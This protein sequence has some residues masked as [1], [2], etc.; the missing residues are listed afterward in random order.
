MSSDFR[1]A[2]RLPPLVLFPLL[3][4][5]VPAH[6]QANAKTAPASLGALVDVGGHRLH[7]HCTGQGSPTVVLE[8]GAG[9]FSF[10][11]PSRA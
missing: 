6:P 5:S 9:D 1:D 8:A 7:L 10:D 3:L 11:R 4:S 2:L